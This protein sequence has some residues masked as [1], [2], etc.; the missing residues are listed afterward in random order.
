MKPVTTRKKWNCD[1]CGDEFPAGTK[2][3]SGKWGRWEHKEGFGV[4][5]MDAEGRLCARCYAKYV[6]APAQLRDR[7]PAR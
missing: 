7:K 5:H 1:E 3:Y 6:G 2:A 4:V